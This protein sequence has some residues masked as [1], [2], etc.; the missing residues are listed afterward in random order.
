M[1]KIFFT[2]HTAVQDVREFSSSSIDY[3]LI[4][5]LFF[6]HHQYIARSLKKE[7]PDMDEDKIFDI[8]KMIN[9][10]CIIKSTLALYGDIGVVQ[11][12]VPSNFSLYD[13]E[14]LCKGPDILQNLLY[15]IVGGANQL[16]P[17]NSSNIPIEFNLMYK[18]H[19]LIPETIP[20]IKFK[21]N[22]KVNNENKEIQLEQQLMT[23]ITNNTFTYEEEEK[24][25][26]E[27]EEKKEEKK[28]KKKKKKECHIIH[29]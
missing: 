16:F 15:H 22:K 17:S 14:H 2:P 4:Y 28:K 3:Y 1:K 12:T 8:T 13:F 6:R 10:L 24:E 7:Y 21:E 18:W 29:G 11:S 9:I 20:I 25:E 23:N 5:I 19:Q 27:I 26:E